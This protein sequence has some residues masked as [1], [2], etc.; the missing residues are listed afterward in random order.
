MASSS[1]SLPPSE[2][3]AVEPSVLQPWLDD[4]S[5]LILDVRTFAAHQSAR[6]PRALPLSVPSTLLKRPRF[7]LAKMASMLPSTEDANRF[8][9]WSTAQSIIVLDAD[10]SSLVEGGNLLG[11]LNKFKA[12]KSARRIVV[13]A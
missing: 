8:M 1:S 3:P 2:F 11:L 7:S 13:I 4:P 9:Q 12:E 10:S 5:A 6:L